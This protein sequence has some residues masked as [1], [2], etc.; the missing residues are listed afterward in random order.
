[1]ERDCGMGVGM[2]EEGKKEKRVGRKKN[3]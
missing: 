1:M 3:R 2:E